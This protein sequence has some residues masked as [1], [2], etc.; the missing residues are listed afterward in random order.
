VAKEIPRK[1]CMWCDG[2][3]KN[4]GN[5]DG[6]GLAIGGIGVIFTNVNEESDE[7]ESFDDY[8]MYYIGPTDQENE[9]A[10][11]NNRMELYAFLED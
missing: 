7:V 10:V 11:T 1:L 8:S 4:N 9:N 3:I 2:A 6:S 5:K